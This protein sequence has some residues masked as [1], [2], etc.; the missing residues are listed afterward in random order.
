MAATSRSD[1][2][3][4]GAPHL[5]GDLRSALVPGDHLTMF[6]EPN[7]RVVARELASALADADPRSSR[8]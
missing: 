4:G 1:A 6:D 8:R 3:L 5:H 7:V 2:S